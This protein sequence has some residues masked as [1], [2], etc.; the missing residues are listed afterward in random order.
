MKYGIFFA[1]VEQIVP[2]ISATDIIYAK[3]FINTPVAIFDD[4]NTARAALKK[5][6]RS[7]RKN[8]DFDSTFDFLVVF[9][10]PCERE[11]DNTDE[12]AAFADPADYV[13]NFDAL[14]ENI[15]IR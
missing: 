8:C 6:A 7:V 13:W 10:A 9:I 5:Y 14:T 3:K 15:I 2:S 1:I 12:P 4:E 11:F